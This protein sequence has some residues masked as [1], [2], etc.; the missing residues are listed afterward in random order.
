ME[1]FVSWIA[2]N[3]LLGGIILFLPIIP[4]LWFSYYGL[5]VISD[6]GLMPQAE[7][8]ADFAAI[9]LEQQLDHLVDVSNVLAERSSFRNL[10]TEERWEDAIV[11]TNPITGS[12]LEES[13]DRIFI[14][15]RTGTLM[16]DS[17]PLQGVRGRNF[18]QRDWYQGVS[19]DWQPYVS[20][21]YQRAAS[22]QYNVVA[23][24]TPIISPNKKDEVAGIL[25]LQIKIDR[26][27]DWR[28]Q[29]KIAP[30]EILYIV[31]HKGHVVAHPE[32]APQ[33]TAIVNFENVPAVQ[34][35]LKGESGSGVFLDPID[36]QRKLMVYRVIQP[37]GWG[38]VIEEPV[39]QTFSGGDFTIMLGVF[40]F[41]VLYAIFLIYLPLRIAK[42]AN[43]HL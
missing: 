27:L 6:R 17:P 18:S 24:S 14:A 35:I 29:I 42:S 32:I 23:I 8:A 5:G 38:V 7:P 12:T 16:A 1:K 26:F 13:I 2:R 22:P 37:Y 34:Q 3:R 25:V 36:Q 4:L 40:S 31:D 10:V 33:G 9:L 41:L 30:S 39:G 15:D 20:G 11:N 28:E 19:R 43:P 21:V